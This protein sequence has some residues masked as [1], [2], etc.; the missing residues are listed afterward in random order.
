MST[1]L[2]AI[3]DLNGNRIIVYPFD[4]AGIVHITILRK[5]EK[6]ASVNLT[7]QKVEAFKAML[8]AAAG[9]AGCGHDAVPER[10][11]DV[12]HYECRRCGKQWDESL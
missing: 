8:D 10:A 6:F 7:P 3:E 9:C 5:D 4:D 12:L 2:N 11:G 1:H